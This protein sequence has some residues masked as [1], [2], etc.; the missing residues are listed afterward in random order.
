MSPAALSTESPMVA[1][2]VVRGVTRMFHHLGLAALAEVPL[3]NSRRADVYAIDAKGEIVICEVKVSLA[4]LRGDMKWP[5]YLDFCDRFFWAVP[6]HIPAAILDEPAFRPE[7]SGVIVADRFDAA[8]L[9]MAP[10]NPLPAARRRTEILR[11]GRL[12]AS[13][14]QR[15]EDPFFGELS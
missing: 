5:D 1:C 10:T 15:A 11:F 13:R 3:R 2:D 9:R 7:I 4:D 8:I 12:A 14:F 6:P